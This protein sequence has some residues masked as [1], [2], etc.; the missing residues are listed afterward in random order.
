MTRLGVATQGRAPG[1]LHGSTGLLPI[2]ALELAV[3]VPRLRWALPFP[4]PRTALLRV[5]LP[6][7]RGRSITRGAIAVALLAFVDDSSSLDSPGFLRRLM[8][9]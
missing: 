6:S 8:F 3:P 7:V 9:V 1:C 5:V 4:D 2:T